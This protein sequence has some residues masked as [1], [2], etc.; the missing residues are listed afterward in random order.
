MCINPIIASGYLLLLRLWGLNVLCNEKKKVRD[1]QLKRKGNRS[2]VSCFYINTIPEYIASG[3]TCKLTVIFLIS[4]S[5]LI[6]F[7]KKV[8]LS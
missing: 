4:T 3:N 2:L 6:F 5:Q 8:K 1:L 7:I